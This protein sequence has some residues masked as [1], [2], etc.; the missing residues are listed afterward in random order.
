MTKTLL[1]FL[2]LLFSI[3]ILN[4]QQTFSQKTNFHFFEKTFD[5]STGIANDQEDIVVF[6]GKIFT[7]NIY[8]I[9]IYDGISWTRDRLSNKSS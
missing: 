1:Q 5:L 8:G 2:F 6:G 4:S 9:E 3:N 7:A